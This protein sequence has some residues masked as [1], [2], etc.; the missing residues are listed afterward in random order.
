MPERGR[1]ELIAG[2]AQAVRDFQTAVDE[3][4]EAAA[5]RLGVIRTDLRML[6]HLT[7]GHALSAGELSKA[8]GLSTAATT[9]ALDRLER[10]G[11]AKRSRSTTDRR[12]V[13]IEPTAKA[14]RALERIYAPL[15][16]DGAEVLARMSARELRGVLTFLEQGASL[17][18][19][20]AARTREAASRRSR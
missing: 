10:D 17:N 8:A 15:G 18:R 9:L 3:L 14:R 20:H 13:L 1:S 7:R 11:W 19:A 6:D 16:A 12:K 2:I 5:A 4:D